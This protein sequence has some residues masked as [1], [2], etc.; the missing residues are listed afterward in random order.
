MSWALERCGG[1]AGPGVA[2]AAVAEDV[3]LGRYTR[4]EAESLF[5]RF[6]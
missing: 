2:V 5:G 3:R 6:D 4:A 1:V